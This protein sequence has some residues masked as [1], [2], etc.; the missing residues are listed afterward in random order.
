L[1]PDI[2]FIALLAHETES[3]AMAADLA[4]GAVTVIRGEMTDAGIGSSVESAR[5]EEVHPGVAG[6]TALARLRTSCHWST[7]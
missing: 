5:I 6:C 1:A 2:F 7:R 4:A 3:I